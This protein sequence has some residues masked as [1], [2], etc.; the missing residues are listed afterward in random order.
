MSKAL[1][2]RTSRAPSD[3]TAPVSY[4]VSTLVTALIQRIDLD[5]RLIPAEIVSKR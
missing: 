4:R 3:L 1:A 2:R 5:S